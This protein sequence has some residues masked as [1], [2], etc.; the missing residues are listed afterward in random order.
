MSGPWPGRAG[1]LLLRFGAQKGKSYLIDNGK[2][3][4]GKIPGDLL[5]TRG[6]MCKSGQSLTDN[7]IFCILTAGKSFIEA[8]AKAF[9]AR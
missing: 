4:A 7:A 3:C 6:R 5:I 2:S 1:R 9:F 8:A